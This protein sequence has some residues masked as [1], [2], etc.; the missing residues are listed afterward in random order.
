MGER[1]R[2]GRGG[3]REP[4]VEPG[5]PADTGAGAGAGAGT[6]L[7]RSS[8]DQSGDDRAAEDQDGDAADDVGDAYHLI[9]VE[10]QV[11]SMK[12]T[13][14]DHTERNRK[15]QTRGDIREQEAPSRLVR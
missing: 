15:C 7:I 11:D 13:D 8:W 12:C 5:L 1:A 4:P 3:N 9:A 6:I 14:H 10:I 2:D